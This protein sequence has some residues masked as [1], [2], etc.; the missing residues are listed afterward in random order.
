MDA[1]RLSQDMFYQQALRRF[2]RFE[3]IALQPPAPVRE[4]MLMA[5]D[6][7]E[8]QGAWKVKGRDLKAGCRDRQKLQSGSFLFEDR[9]PKVIGLVPVLAPR[10]QVR[11]LRSFCRSTTPFSDFVTAISN[12]YKLRK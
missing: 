5:L 7:E 4:L 6:V 2:G 12:T 10:C 8:A 9:R 1:V 11:L 3:R